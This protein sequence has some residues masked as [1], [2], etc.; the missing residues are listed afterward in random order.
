[1]DLAL[2]LCID[3]FIRFFGA[4]RSATLV[5]TP[6]EFVHMSFFGSCD[7]TQA[8]RVNAPSSCILRCIFAFAKTEI[9]WFSQLIA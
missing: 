9:V 6:F 4:V 2:A 7:G 3:A 5:V 8:C 1:M